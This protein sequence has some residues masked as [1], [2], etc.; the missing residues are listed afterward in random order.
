MAADPIVQTIKEAALAIGIILAL[1]LIGA[2][3]LL[4]IA[5][6]QIASVD[7]PEDADFFETLQAVPIT[8]PLALDLLDLAFDF[9]A[10][11]IAWIILELLGLQ[12]LQ[13]I[14]VVEGLIPGT[15]LIPTLTIA[16]LIARGMKKKKRSSPLRES[17]AAY[18]LEERRARYG[19]LRSGADLADQYRRKALP[20]PGH[21]DD[22]VEGEYFEEDLDELP[23]EYYENEQW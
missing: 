5:A 4:I 20:M 3:T 8:V 23:P 11:P 17:L 9:F 2:I 15:Q 22:V 12:S 1:A 13:L 7:V 10:A 6:R 16:W 21:K 18:Q 14:T 19:R